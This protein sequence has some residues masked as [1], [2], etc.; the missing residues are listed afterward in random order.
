MC[1]TARLCLPVV[2]TGH[3][4]KRLVTIHH[5]HP[6]WA[7][8]SAVSGLL[9]LY[10]VPILSCYA[11]SLLF[12]SLSAC[13]TERREGVSGGIS[14]P[15]L[16]PALAESTIPVY[17]VPPPPNATYTDLLRCCPR[18]DGLLWSPAMPSQ[19]IRSPRIRRDRQCLS[20]YPPRPWR[21]SRVEPRSN[22]S[23]ARIS[24]FSHP[25]HHPCAFVDMSTED[26]HRRLVVYHALAA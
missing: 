22:S 6:F 8:Y 10:I 12:S 3:N 1:S 26:T 16:P 19:A 5:L 15:E 17:T 11:T 25:L 21:H 14:L 24:R 18:L 9:H 20:A 2:I 13:G 23:S 4:N 7:L